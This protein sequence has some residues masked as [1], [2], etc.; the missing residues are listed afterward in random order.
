VRPTERC[1]LSL[2]CDTSKRSSAGPIYCC[3]L[4]LF[5]SPLRANVTMVYHGSLLLYRYDE[6]IA[7]QADAAAARALSMRLPHAHRDVLSYLCGYLKELTGHEDVTS[8]GAPN[9][10]VRVTQWLTINPS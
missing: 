8:M 6:A 7:A 1:W 3:I 5:H 2:C 10:A 4:L 9:L